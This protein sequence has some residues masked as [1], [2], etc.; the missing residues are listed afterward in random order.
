MRAGLAGLWPAGR[1]LWVYAAGVTLAM[2]LAFFVFNLNKQDGLPVEGF[3]PY[4][5][6]EEQIAN[7]EFKR[8]A[9]A[10]SLLF[11]PPDASFKPNDEIRFRWQAPKGVPVSL[12]ILNNKGERQYRYVVDKSEFLFNAGLPAGL[13]YWK[14]ATDDDY[15]MGKFVVR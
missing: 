15:P 4:A 7:Q 8:S 2:L 3:Q 13:Y 6:F 10:F 5:Y 14:I 12:E 9:Q 1:R 11:P